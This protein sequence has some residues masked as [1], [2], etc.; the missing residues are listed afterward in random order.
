[1]LHRTQVPREIPAD[2][3]R[4]DDDFG[5]EPPPRHRLERL[6][7]GTRQTNHP[8]GQSVECISDM[9]KVVSDGSLAERAHVVEYFRGNLAEYPKCPFVS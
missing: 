4:F 6:G 7:P 5:T 8:G 3:Q 1:M 2:F 9:V